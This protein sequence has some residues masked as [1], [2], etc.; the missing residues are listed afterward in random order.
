MCF[1]MNPSHVSPGNRLDQR[2]GDDVEDVVVGEALAEAGRRFQ[3]AQRVDDVR[4]RARGR[5]H[6]QKVPF[7]EAEAAAMGKKIAHGHVRGRI[8]IVHLE[9]G[10][11]VDDPV[12]PFKL[13]GIDED[14][15][16]RRR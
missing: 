16:R 7:P 12:V 11:L 2:A 15:Q 1:W 14:R 10:K 5:R 8:G 4:T 6:D 3:V 9:A 13:P